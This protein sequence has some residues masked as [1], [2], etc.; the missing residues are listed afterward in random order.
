MLW[1]LF[2]FNLLQ[3]TKTFILIDPFEDSI[4][5]LL[6]QSFQLLN[7]KFVNR[8]S[9]NKIANQTINSVAFI[10]Y[11][12]LQTKV[13]NIYINIKF[14]LTFVLP[15]YLFLQFILISSFII[16]LHLVNNL[17]IFLVKLLIFLVNL[18]LKLL[19]P[20]IR[21]VL[22]LHRL[23][24]NWVV[25]RS[26]FYSIKVGYR[27]LTR[28]SCWNIRFFVIYGG[29]L[30]KTWFKFWSLARLNDCGQPSINSNSSFFSC[31]CLFNNPETVIFGSF[32]GFILLS[33][34]LSSLYKLFKT[35]NLILVLNSPYTGILFAKLINLR[36]MSTFL[37][38]LIILILLLIF[39]MT[40]GKL[41][42]FNSGIQIKTS[43]PWIVFV[44]IKLVLEIICLWL[45]C[46]FTF[47][48][49]NFRWI[50][51]VKLFL[52]DFSFNFVLSVQKVDNI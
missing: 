34:Y 27:F 33:S 26:T 8:T 49:L 10:N 38:I 22:R 23:L 21:L 48:L 4:Y 17:L 43:I 9:F 47:F 25:G 30:S 50:N 29:W 18:L 41:S 19:K 16:D 12:S 24:I 20:K 39:I 11:D 36:L 13:S 37:V 44:L 2:A 5:L 45:E 42:L 28:L 52:L 46:S 32:Q 1:W 51:S 35:F 14:W 6:K 3:I 40:Q 7:H 31:L 15:I